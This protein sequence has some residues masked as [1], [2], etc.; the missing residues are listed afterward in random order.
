MSERNTGVVKWFNDEKG[1]GFIVPDK[2]GRDVF[3]H[4]SAVKD[5]HYDSIAEGDRVEYELK[6]GYN[7]KESATN[8]K[9]IS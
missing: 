4:I 7:D 6:K 2:G 1:F 9:I 8:I 3:I 5:A